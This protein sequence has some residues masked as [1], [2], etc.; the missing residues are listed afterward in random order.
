MILL[1]SALKEDFGRYFGKKMLITQIKMRQRKYLIWHFR[2]I[3]QIDLD[4]KIK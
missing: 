3:Y 1:S 2:Y 4:G